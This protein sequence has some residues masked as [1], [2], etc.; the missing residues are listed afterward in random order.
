MFSSALTSSPPVPNFTNN[1]SDRL[2]Y[3]VFEAWRG[4]HLWL[5]NMREAFQL[6]YGVLKQ[7]RTRKRCSRAR[8]SCFETALVFACSG[9]VTG[10]YD[11]SYRLV[12]VGGR[13]LDTYAQRKG[14]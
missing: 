13:T 1:S 6:K 9:G 5:R 12:R 8:V 10:S 2:D 7:V 3:K 11:K 4:F 14:G